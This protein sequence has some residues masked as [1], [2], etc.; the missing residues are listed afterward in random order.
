MEMGATDSMK[1]MD[2][3]NKIKILVFGSHERWNFEKTKI[4]VKE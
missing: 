2:R 1:I 3:N 4:A